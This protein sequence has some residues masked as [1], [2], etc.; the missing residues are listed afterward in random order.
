MGEPERD[1]TDGYEVRHCDRPM[2]HTGTGFRWSGDS[3]ITTYRVECE[4]CG[5]KADLVLTAHSPAP[6]KIGG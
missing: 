6:S 2:R 1:Y 5:A 3:E 4:T